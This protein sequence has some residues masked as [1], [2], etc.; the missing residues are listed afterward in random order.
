MKYLAP[1][2]AVFLLAGCASTPP[3]REITV[4]KEVPVPYHEPCP[5]QADKPVVP[6]HVADEHPQMPK[7]ADGTTDWY[8]VSRILGAKIIELFGYADRADGIMTACSKP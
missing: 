4:T 6:K 8:A 5:K 2:A 1:L 7:A 3:P